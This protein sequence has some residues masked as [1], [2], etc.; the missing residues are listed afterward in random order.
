MHDSNHEQGGH[1]MTKLARRGRRLVIGGAAVAA[2]AGGGAAAALATDQGSSDVYRACL[3]HNLSALYNVKVN[4]TTPPRCLQR[5]TVI[6]WNQTGPAGAA[7]PQG[8]KGDVGPAGPKGDTGPVGP[9]GAKGDTGAKGDIGPAGAKG[10]TGPA[11][12]AGPQGAT[13]DT[14][15]RGPAGPA[16][17]AGVAFHTASDVVP[18]NQWL[19]LGVPCPTG[20]VATGGGGG[21]LNQGDIG[22]RITRST[23]VVTGGVPTGWQVVVD[24]TNAAN[25]PAY[26]E[27]ICAPAG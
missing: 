8:A 10:D 19:A 14:G 17:V 20:Q 22:L 21:F 26:V 12:P 7:G 2:V 9:A 15:P 4:P 5:D 13:G 6:S 18:P 25:E 3:N 23:P 11:G 24:S 16:G 1:L 27:V